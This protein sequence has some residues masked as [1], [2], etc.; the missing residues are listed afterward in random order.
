[1]AIGCWDEDSTQDAYVTWS[2]FMED[3]PRW[4]PICGPLWLK[5]PPITQIS[6]NKR[7][8][9]NELKRCYLRKLSPMSKNNQ[10]ISMPISDLYNTSLLHKIVLAFNLFILQPLRFEIPSIPDGFK[11]YQKKKKSQWNKQKHL[12]P[13]SGASFDGTRT[14]ESRS[15]SADHVPRAKINYPPP[16]QPLAVTTRRRNPPPTGDS[17]TKDF[18]PLLAVRPTTWRGMEREYISSLLSFDLLGSST[19]HEQPKVS[20]LTDLVALDPHNPRFTQPTTSKNKQFD[21][22]LYAKNR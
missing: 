10:I 2:Q 4:R 11:E 17:F 3:L 13:Y 7:Q 12:T 1:M 15:L 18:P 22:P 20:P 5:S 6:D 14:Q 16:G 21:G 9:D 19:V 8:R